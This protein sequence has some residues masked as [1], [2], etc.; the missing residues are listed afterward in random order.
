MKKMDRPGVGIGVWIVKGNKVLLG[1]R[2]SDH[3]HGTWA[4]PGGKLDMNESW[5]ACARRET[6]EETGLKIKNIRYCGATNNVYRKE[7]RHYVTIHMVADWA[8]GEAKRMEPEK[9]AGWR[10]FSWRKL[11]TPLMPGS[12]TFV[13][14]GYNPLDI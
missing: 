9:C 8:A 6:E 13:K 3:A 14:T 12:R 7:G 10:W 11:P 5:E 4:P 1:K 2:I